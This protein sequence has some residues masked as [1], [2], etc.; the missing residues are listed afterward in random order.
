MQDPA[1]R[2]G[3]GDIRRRPSGEQCDWPPQWGH[4]VM[5]IWKTRRIPAA[6][7][8]GAVGGP[9]SFSAGGFCGDDGTRRLHGWRLRAALPRG[10]GA[11]RARGRH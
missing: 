3:L 11:L 6:Q 9:S 4:V 2:S 8:I 7:V 5:S 1:R 10:G